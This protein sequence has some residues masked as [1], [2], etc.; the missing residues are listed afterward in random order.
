[1]TNILNFLQY[2]NEKDEQLIEQLFQKAHSSH[3]RLDA[4][5]ESK[6]LQVEDH[7]LFLAF[8]TYL[9]EQKI[10]AQQLFKDVIHL[11][12]YQF[13]ARYAMN[14]GQVVRLSVTFL[15]ILRTNDLE[16]YKQIME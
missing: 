11:P 4:L 1:M 16:S 15:T 3:N 10:P 14:W 13:E 5:L 12:K 7:K 8:L 9:E 2:K 6:Q